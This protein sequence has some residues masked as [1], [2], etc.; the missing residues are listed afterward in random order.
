MVGRCLWI[1][2]VEG[3]ELG[4]PAA[5]GPGQPVIEGG[6]G[7]GT[8]ELPDEPELFE[9]VRPER[10]H[11]SQQATVNGFD[12][13]VPARVARAVYNG[14][15]MQYQLHV[16]DRLSWTVR[17]QHA[18]GGQKRFLPGEAVTVRWNRDESVV[19]A[20]VVHEGS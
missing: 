11:V 10:L 19:L 1:D 20:R 17:I 18:D 12:N 5:A 13:V 3:D 16:A 4:D 7:V 6:E 8:A 15:E 14:H 2:V 9:E